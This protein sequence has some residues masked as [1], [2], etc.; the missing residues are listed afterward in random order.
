M[1]EDVRRFHSV[2]L[3]LLILASCS[4]STPARETETFEPPPH[5][6]PPR[7]KS[8]LTYKQIRR[9]LHSDRIDIS[10]L[11]GRYFGPIDLTA[12]QVEQTRSIDFTAPSNVDFLGEAEFRRALKDISNKQNAKEDRVDRWLEWSLGHRPLGSDGSSSPPGDPV[13]RVAGFYAYGDKRVVVK[14]DE[15]LDGEFLTLAHELAH[16][17]A[18]QVFGLPKKTRSPIVDD[19]Q[20]ARAALVEGD[21]TLVEMRFHSRFSSKKDVKQYIDGLIENDREFNQNRDAGTPYAILERFIF[22]YR[23]G[24]HF[25]CTLFKKQG[26]KGVDRAFRH[27]PTTTAEILFPER[28]LKGRNP[29][30][31]PDLGK[32]PKPWKRFA[33][34]GI[35]PAHL[36]VLFE[37]PLDYEP[38]AL[39]NPLARAASWNGGH[40]ELWAT[41]IRETESALGISMLEHPHHPGLLCSSMIKWYELTFPLGEQEVIGDGVVSYADKLRTTIISCADGAVRIGMAPTRDLAERLLG[42]GGR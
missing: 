37:A 27:P 18:D 10:A 23:W 29:K 19:A 24:L 35:G 26:W 3:A 5:V 30:R 6:R 16:A 15:E 8:K 31:A 7:M 4:G 2:A 13:E 12:D 32:L 9:C 40:Y 21:A 36:K 25:V 34:E 33:K 39:S 1:G 11:A 41:G 17:A 22:P 42:L 38:K 28:Y 20:L 14:Q